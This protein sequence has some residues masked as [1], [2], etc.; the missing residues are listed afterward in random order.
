MGLESFDDT[1]SERVA[2]ERQDFPSGQDSSAGI[3]PEKLAA[4][5]FSDSKNKPFLPATEALH[6]SEYTPKDDPGE[7]DSPYDASVFA[8]LKSVFPLDEEPSLPRQG[9]QTMFPQGE[10][11]IDDDP[12]EDDGRELE[13]VRRALL[14]Q[15]MH[16]GDELVDP[17]T[18]ESISPTSLRLYGDAANA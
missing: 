3:D 7:D 12:L 6:T 4:L 1:F 11:P 15:Q 9:N 17:L 8:V 5:K 13:A 2:R 10:A 18:G 16:G 14:F